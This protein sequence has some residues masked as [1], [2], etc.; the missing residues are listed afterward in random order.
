MGLSYTEKGLYDEIKDRNNTIRIS[1]IFF[2]HYFLDEEKENE[3]N[4]DF[5]KKIYNILLNY[6]EIGQKEKEILKKEYNDILNVYNN[7]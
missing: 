3:I 6:N 1:I 2:R 4:I 5:L 7:I